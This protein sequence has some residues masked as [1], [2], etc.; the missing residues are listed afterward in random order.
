MSKFIVFILDYYMCN[1][2]S[3]Q[4]AFFIVCTYDYINPEQSPLKA[5]HAA[6]LYTPRDRKKSVEASIWE[7]RACGLPDA[8]FVVGI[9]TFGRCWTLGDNMVTFRTVKVESTEAPF[10]VSFERCQI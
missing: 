6:P 4:I 3:N 1:A 5:D 2:L 7:W 9:P 10:N 8:K